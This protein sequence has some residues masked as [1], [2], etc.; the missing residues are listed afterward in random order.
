MLAPREREAELIQR[1]EEHIQRYD[2]LNE[3]LRE[4]ERL[5]SVS[6]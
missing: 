5:R 1:E 4:A 2:Q 3:A 6:T